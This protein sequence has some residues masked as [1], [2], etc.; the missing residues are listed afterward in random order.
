MAEILIIGAIAGMLLGLRFKVFVL[1]PVV[2]LATMV[3]IGI[4][5]ASSHGPVM[6]ALMALGA[7]VS[8]QIGY[9][10]GVLLQVMVLAYLP[11]LY[12]RRETV[13]RAKPAL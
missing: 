2:F 4:G 8:L 12:R 6:I 10:A 1:A 13:E 9:V 11:S 3:I 5:A 7:V